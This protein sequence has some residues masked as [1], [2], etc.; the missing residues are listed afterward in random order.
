MEETT[1]S[2]HCRHGVGA[3]R[4]ERRRGELGRKAVGHLSPEG[5]HALQPLS[6]RIAG[7]QGGVDRA[8]GGSDHP[9]GLDAEFL[10]GLVDAGLVGAQG[11]TA[12]ED[13]DDLAQLGLVDRVACG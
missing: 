3:G 5:A 10:Q 8:D 1:E 2:G 6:G 13:K 9:I 12:L 11:A 7:D 4:S